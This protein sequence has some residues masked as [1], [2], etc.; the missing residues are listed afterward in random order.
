M[1]W[2]FIAG[3]GVFMLGTFTGYS[4]YAVATQKILGTPGDT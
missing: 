2:A 3:A 1:I 4:I